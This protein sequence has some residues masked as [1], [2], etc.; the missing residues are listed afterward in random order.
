MVITVKCDQMDDGWNWDTCLYCKHFDI[1]RRVGKG[2]N[3]RCKLNS[4]TAA[5]KREFYLIWA[6]NRLIDYGVLDEGSQDEVIVDYIGKKK[7]RRKSDETTP[8]KSG[9]E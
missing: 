9:F 3:W 8:D 7:R 6:T 5:E 4:G 1:Q 2:T